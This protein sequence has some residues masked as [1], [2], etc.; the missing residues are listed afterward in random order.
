M[1][2]RAVT[3]ARTSYDDRE[4]DGRN[5]QGQLDMC[6][7]YALSHNWHVVAELAEDDHGAS[8]ADW[9]LPGLTKALEMARAGEFDVLVVRELDR[10]ARGLAK[11]LV[12]EEEFRQAKVEVAYVLGEYADTPEGNLQKGFRA[13]LAEYERVKIVDR[14]QRGRRLK[15]QAGNVMVLGC[16]PYG[17]RSAEKDGKATLEVDDAEAEIVRMIYMWYLEGD[18]ERGPMGADAIARRLTEMHAPTYVDTGARRKGPRKQKKYGEWGRSAV[19]EILRGEVYA[20]VWR[21]GKRNGA[22]KNPNSHTLGVPVPAIVTRETWAATQERMEHKKRHHRREPRYNYLL[23]KRLICGACGQKLTGLSCPR[24]GRV[25]LYYRCPGTYNSSCAH[26][27]SSPLFRADYVDAI[28]WD[29]LKEKL[30]DPDRLVQG[31]ED[32]QA[33]QDKA[34]EPIRARLAVIESLIADNRKQLERLLDLYV[35]GGFDKEM[36]S[37][38]KARLEV[39]LTDLEKERTAKLIQLKGRTMTD[40]EIQT[41]REFAVNINKGFD[42]TTFEERL[43]MIEL[44]NVTATLTVENEEKVAYVECVLPEERRRCLPIVQHY[45]GYAL[46]NA[47]DRRLGR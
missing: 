4:N 31:L 24:K 3:Y 8:G 38:R 28:V 42:A 25:I 29:W 6:R 22:K 21:Y 23:G 2:K 9:D 40:E 30:S 15:I 43:T 34:N 5:L 19:L 39:T 17:Y 27:C 37:E 7:E 32:Y 47:F 41:I 35:T 44:L 13:V 45:S 36:L 1:S 33:E 10:F 20:G 11:Q 26:P 46:S 12:I 14:T 16:P 18:G